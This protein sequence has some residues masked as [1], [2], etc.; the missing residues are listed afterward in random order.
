M[1]RDRGM[2]QGRRHI[3]YLVQLVLCFAALAIAA[4]PLQQ[5]GKYVQPDPVQRALVN[6]AAA[7]PSPDH[8]AFA[9]NADALP[10]P[11]Q[12]RSSGSAI[13][14]SKRGLFGAQRAAASAA[15]P[16]TAADLVLGD[17]VIATTIEGG[18]YGIERATGRTLWTVPPGAGSSKKGPEDGQP[19]DRDGNLFSPL[20]GTSYGSKR[21]DFTELLQGL[22]RPSSASSD[23]FGP[24]ALTDMEFFVVEPS[25][26]G[27]IYVLSINPADSSS[28]G[29]GAVPG[30]GAQLEK[31]PL[32]VPQ[33][34]ELSPFSF[35]GDDSRVFAGHKESKLVEIDVRTGTLGAVF[36]GEAG[37]WC[38]ADEGRWGRGTKPKDAC[39]DD[40]QSSSDHEWAYIGRTGASS[41]MS[42]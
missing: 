23:A 4:Y 16:Q 20:V 30:A 29:P 27:D 8:P 35:A 42:S 31:L 19:R 24:A 21:H 11:A 22:S 12:A 39:A 2:I 17:M 41:L 40:E 32:T 37:V 33:L 28:S 36:G 9:S 18:L 25:S 7:Q 3:V 34:V 14:L 26:A 15:R 10:V 5:S 6:A 1:P 13:S 38:G